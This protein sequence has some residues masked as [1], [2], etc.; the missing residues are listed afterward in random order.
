MRDALRT[1]AGRLYADRGPALHHAEQGKLALMRLRLG[2]AGGLSLLMA[3]SWLAGAV[4]AAV[5]G[6]W[7]GAAVLGVFAVAFLALAGWALVRS[8][9]YGNAAKGRAVSATP[10]RLLLG[11]SPPPGHHEDGGKHGLR[12]TDMVFD[13]P[14]GEL[15]PRAHWVHVGAPTGPPS[16]P[17]RP[18]PG[19]IYRFGTASRPGRLGLFVGANGE[20]LLFDGRPRGAR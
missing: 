18:V 16:G 20:R 2:V 5:A 3:V 13:T 6:T 10:V 11:H 4:I 17:V 9:P 12:R 8:H 19:T 15:R 7:A 1:P 14:D